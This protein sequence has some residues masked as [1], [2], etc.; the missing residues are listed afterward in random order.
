MKS[1]ATRSWWSFALI[2]STTRY[3]E[4]AGANL[5]IEAVFEDMPIK[6]GRRRGVKFVVV[7]MCV[8]GGM[9]AVGLFE[10]L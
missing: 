1:K 7:T 3:E 8:G 5:V 10:V 6:E 9:G 4:L 2:R